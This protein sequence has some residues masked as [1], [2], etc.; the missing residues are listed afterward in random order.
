VLSE[1]IVDGRY[2]VTV[3]GLAGSQGMFFVYPPDGPTPAPRATATAG[4]TVGIGAEVEGSRNR[5]FFVTF[6]ATG[7]NADG[8]ATVQLTLTQVPL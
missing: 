3:E 2:V 1:R 7:A 4:A 5:M 8:Y 6:P